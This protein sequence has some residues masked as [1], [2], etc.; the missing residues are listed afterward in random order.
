MIEIWLI[1]HS[2]TG[3]NSLGRYIGRTD[4][5][6]SEEG[7]SLLAG[8]DYGE[9]E[10][11]YASP[12]KRCVQTARILFPKQ[13]PILVDAFRECDFGEFENKNYRELAGNPRYQEWVDSGGT[14]AFPG[15][16]DS[17]TFRRRCCLGFCRVMEELLKETCGRA[18]LVVHGGTIMSILEAFGIPEKSFYDWQISNAQGYVLQADLEEWK[19]EKKIHV[20]KKTNI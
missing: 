9:P 6:L 11:V 17:L 2:K 16:E 10:R 7:I 14:L 18:A 19:R 3:G 8:L 15:G 12:M 13:A 20:L 1:R 5:E 4:E